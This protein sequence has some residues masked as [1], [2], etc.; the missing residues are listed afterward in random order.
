MQRSGILPEVQI[1]YETWGHLAAE[2][3]NAVLLF[4][5]LSPSAH[6][7]SSPQDPTPGWWESMVGPR[8]PIDTRRFY[9]VCVNSLGSCF[10]STGP[11]SLDLRSGQPYRLNFPSLTVEDIARA[12]REAL[13]MLGIQRLHAVIGASLGGMSALAYALQ[14]P[15]EIEQLIV[16]SAAARATPFAI[17]VRSLQRE[18]IRSDPAWNGG[19]YETGRGPFTGMRLARKLGLISYRSA[20]EWQ[21]R[22]GRERVSHGTAKDEPFGVE[23]QIESYLDANA[24]KLAETFDANCYLYLSRAIDGFDATE[25]GSSL[26]DALARIRAHRILVIGVETDFLFPLWQQ[27]EL[28]D[29][30]SR[31]GCEVELAVLPSVHGHDAFL[32]DR[33]HFAPVIEKFLGTGPQ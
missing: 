8:K 32:V 22:F 1:A 27:R 2:R 19:N 21:E 20:Q 3:D 23:F 16:I 26:A 18:I 5:G 24:R 28:A 13:R 30:L 33:D 29:V 14:F 7:A 4:T 31:G 10:G 12:A 6:A 9:V 25:H 15:A 11:A 17:A